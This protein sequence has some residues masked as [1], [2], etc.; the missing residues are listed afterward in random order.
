VASAAPLPS[1]L[2]ESKADDV[3]DTSLLLATELLAQVTEA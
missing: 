2:G 1:I 3:A